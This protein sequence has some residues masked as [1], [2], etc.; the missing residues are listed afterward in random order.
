MA[1]S[2]PPTVLVDAK[3]L[4]IAYARPDGGSI[5]VLYRVNLQVRAGEILAVLGPSG[6]GKSSLLRV[7]AGLLRPTEGTVLYRGEPL[8]GPNPGV[9]MVFQ[10]FALFPWLTVLDNVE[11]GLLAQ[12]VAQDRARAKALEM[13]DLIGLDGFESAFPKELSGGMRQRV[14]FARA[15]AVEPDIL[16][17]DEPF[18]A[19]D[20][21]TAENL[22]TD[23]L[24]LWLK[25]RFP[26]R[27]IVV[28]THSI[29]EAVFMADR[30]I[31]LAT[32]PGRIVD[33]VR[34]E[35][36][37]WRDR[38]STQFQQVV[39]R[40]YELL[41]GDRAR[42][43][44]HLKQ[45]IP[46]LPNATVSMLIGLVELIHDR[47]N[48]ADLAQVGAELHFDVE[49]LLPA[50]EAA[51]LLGFA[52]AHAGDLKLTELGAALAA[53]T[54]QEKKDIFRARLLETVGQTREI[55]AQLN[56][57]EDHR[58]PASGILDELE[59]HFSNEEARRQLE[60]LIGWGR[61]A[62]IYAFDELTDDFYLEPGGVPAEAGSG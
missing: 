19:L 61:Y 2:S 37:H 53:A 26:T 31:V 30:I 4:T 10:T 58:M 33:E 7:L 46:R 6:C 54:V 27:A 15:L 14:G 32:T 23:L 39:E 21:L 11:L 16:L 60:I 34:P 59:R 12:G 20:P 5:A 62:E 56:Q 42:R 9:A 38:R 49:D 57:T 40:V 50:V 35:L 17:M 8:K 52:T 22:R 43:L 28:V 41:T 55:V 51:D 25:R 13:I 36:P 45:L 29:E 3:D 18:S 1:I 24:E 48:E 44:A 47:G